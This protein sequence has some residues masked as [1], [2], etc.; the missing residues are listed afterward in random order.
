MTATAGH[1]TVLITGASSGIGRATAHRFARAGWRVAATMREPDRARDALPEGAV[2]APRLDVTDPDSIAAAVAE[3]REA[4]GAIDVVVNNAGFGVNGPVEAASDAQR[5]R[6]FEVNLFGVMAVMDAVLPAMRARGEGVIVNVSSLAG[7]VGLPGA[8]LYHASKFAL[9]GLTESMRFELAPF[10]VRLKLVEP[11]AIATDFFTRSADW[12][13]HPDYADWTRK[14]REG[15]ERFARK[16][17]LSPPE[18][19]AETIFRA[20]TDG[21]DRLRY[22]SRS[23]GFLTASRLVPDRAWRWFVGR[24][25]AR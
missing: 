13:E 2:I 18:P 15:T 17:P 1:R 16:G 20:A 10:G 11:G 22:V 23:M 5:R 8:P 6:Q 25:I 4:F 12:G 3:T 14:L 9:E 21:S 19:V 7:R 24:M